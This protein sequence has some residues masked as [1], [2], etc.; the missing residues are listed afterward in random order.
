MKR[1]VP[2]AGVVLCAMA[3]GACGGG[4]SAQR[5]DGLE[6]SGAIPKL[7]RGP[8]LE[9]IDANGNGIRDDI[10][11]FIERNYSTEA[12]RRAASQLAAHFK[13]TILVDKSDRNALRRQAVLGAHAVGCVN[14]RF[15]GAGGSKQA[16]AVVYEL[17]AVT[18]NTKKR[19]K[20]YFA[21]AKGLDGAVISMPEGDTCVLPES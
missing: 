21:Y 4:L 5:V 16:A 13:K 11:A 18:A 1:F 14:D 10:D 7:D 6:A 15:N 3:F 2:R 19:L 17:E 8:S 9:G 12:Q 20:A